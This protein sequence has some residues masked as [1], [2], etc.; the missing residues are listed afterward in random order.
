MHAVYVDGKL[1]FVGDFNIANTYG[2][3]AASAGSKVRTTQA[4]ASILEVKKSMLAEID[5]KIAVVRAI[6]HEKLAVWTSGHEPTW[7]AESRIKTAQRLERLEDESL[8]L[9]GIYEP[10]NPWANVGVTI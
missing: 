2:R 7:R 10:T 6:Y 5:S 8:A 3:Q 4:T 1:R 9:L